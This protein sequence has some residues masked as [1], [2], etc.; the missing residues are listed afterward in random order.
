MTNAAKQLQIDNIANDILASGICPELANV[1]TRLVM[2]DGNLDARIVLI[3]EA[4]GK[5]EDEAGLPFVGA[6]GKF[7]DTCLESINLKRDQIYITNIVKYRPPANRDPT[8]DEKQAFWPYLARQLEI[9]EPELIVT[10]GRHSLEFFWPE[11]KISQVHGQIISRKVTFPGGQPQ[12]LL[13]LPLYHPAAALYNG[14]MRS[15]L[16]EDFQAIR[17]FL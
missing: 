4:P 17:E 16:I 13:I 8:E 5:R 14:S 12:E 15:V 3:G 9:I 11:V 1:A 2:G 10:L 7:L 6:A